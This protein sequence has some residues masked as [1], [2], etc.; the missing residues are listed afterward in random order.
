METKISSFFRSLIMPALGGAC[1]VWSCVKDGSKLAGLFM[2][3][4]TG[5]GGTGRDLPLRAPLIP[6][7]GWDPGPDSY[8]TKWT[9]FTSF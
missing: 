1:D 4:E 6:F 3:G 8:I 5:G 2:A 9:L 7:P